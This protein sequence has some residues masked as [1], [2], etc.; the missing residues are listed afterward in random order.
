[1][2]TTSVEDCVLLSLLQIKCNKEEVKY[3]PLETIFTF[4]PLTRL[5]YCPILQLLSK[6]YKRQMNFMFFDITYRHESVQHPDLEVAK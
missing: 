5:Q 2:V 3:T 6:T 4:N 1:M